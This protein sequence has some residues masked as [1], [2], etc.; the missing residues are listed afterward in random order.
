MARLR[1]VLLTVLV[2]HPSSRTMSSDPVISVTPV[3]TEK[4]VVTHVRASIRINASPQAVWEILSDCGRAPQLIPHL[5]SC[6]IVA[7]DPHGRWDVRE[8]I[9]NPPILPKM[10]TLVRNEFIHSKQL[11][12]RLMSGDMRA[13]DGAWTLRP[14]GTET[15]LSYDAHVAPKLAVPQFMVANS[16][17]NE[18][19]RM[20]RAISEASSNANR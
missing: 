18:F 7:R 10:R 12:F 16:I 3:R 9:I 4:G 13:S 20:L 5:E 8:H 2:L 1:F 6:R 11:S 14:E 15:I 19:P 17:S